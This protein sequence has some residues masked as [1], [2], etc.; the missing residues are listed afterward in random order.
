MLRLSVVLRKFI[1]CFSLYT[2]FLMGYVG[3]H[4]TVG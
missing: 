3:E 2:T 1:L 4:A